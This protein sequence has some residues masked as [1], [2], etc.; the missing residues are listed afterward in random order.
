MAG[1]VLHVAISTSIVCGLLTLVR[2]G[3]L[4]VRNPTAASASFW[5]YGSSFNAFTLL[6]IV[7]EQSVDAALLAIP[8]LVVLALQV[9][10]LAVL[11]LKPF[12][13]FDAVELSQAWQILR[14]FCCLILCE[15]LRRQHVRL[16][17]VKISI[18]TWWLAYFKYWHSTAQQHITVHE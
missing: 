15:M 17:L 12:R 16:D 9:R 7:S 3:P 4:S 8:S 11:S 10:P 13:T 5:E 18:R 1:S 14:R 6:C 2:S